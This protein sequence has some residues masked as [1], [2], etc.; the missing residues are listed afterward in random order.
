MQLNSWE[1]VLVNCDSSK[2]QQQ[3][4]ILKTE[5][6]QNHIYICK[7]NNHPSLIKH[8]CLTAHHPISK[9]AYRMFVQDF[10]TPIKPNNEARDLRL[11]E[12]DLGDPSQIWQMNSTTHQLANVKYPKV[13]ITTRNGAD[14]TS[15]VECNDYGFKSLNPRLTNKHHQRFNF[16][17]V[18]DKNG[19]QLCS[20]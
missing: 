10:F 13:C 5:N 6:G 16:T 1:I 14:K 12:Y 20:D 11:L 19:D 9:E 8:N 3:W 15:L 18:L 7:R 2:T 17:P 4:V